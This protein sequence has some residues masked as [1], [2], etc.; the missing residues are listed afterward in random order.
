MQHGQYYKIKPE[1]LLL[2]LHQR[3]AG[4]VVAVCV[5]GRHNLTGHRVEHRQRWKRPSYLSVFRHVTKLFGWFLYSTVVDQLDA[6]SKG[7]I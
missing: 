6:M 7:N 2:W 4:I 1:C 5:K 3:H